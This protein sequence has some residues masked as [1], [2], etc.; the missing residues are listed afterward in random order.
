MRRAFSAPRTD[1]LYRQPVINVKPET[2]N[3]FDLGA[4]YIAGRFQ[5]Q[6]TFWKIG[7]Q[8]RIVTSFDPETNTSI[9]RNVGKVSSWGFDAGLGFKPV[10]AAEPHRPAELHR[11]EA[12]GR[13]HHRDGEL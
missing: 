4:R 3:S 10:R 9:D 13:H 1:N 7:Y 12:E 6:G 11:R 5:A 2:T 8:N